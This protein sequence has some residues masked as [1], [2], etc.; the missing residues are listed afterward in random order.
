MS[1]Y[2]GCL[3]W[4]SRVEIPTPFQSTILSE[5]HAGHPGVLRMKGLARMHVWWPGITK[6]IENTV[7]GCLECQ[8]HQSTPPVAPLHP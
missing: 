6:D 4:G 7:R 2:E 3:L 8:Q 5:L 1:L